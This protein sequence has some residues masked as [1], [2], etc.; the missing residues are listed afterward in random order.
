GSVPRC[1][2]VRFA[3]ETLSFCLRENIDNRVRQFPKGIDY[4]G[5]SFAQGLH[6][7]GVRAAAALDDRSR[8]TESCAFA[9]SL[10]ADISDHRLVD[11]SSDNELCQFFLLRRTD[12]AE[13]DDSFCERI[14]LEHQRGVGNSN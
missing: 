9:R 14:G 5:T 8:V 4:S 11:L 6:F 2:P 10:A 1:F 13:D 3:H 7:T 12:F